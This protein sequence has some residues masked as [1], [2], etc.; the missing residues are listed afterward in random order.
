MLKDLKRLADL[1]LDESG[2][3]QWLLIAAIMVG[4]GYWGYQRYI[5]TPAYDAYSSTGNY[6]NAGINGN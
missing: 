6:L 2:I 4:L 1:M 3:L 5:K